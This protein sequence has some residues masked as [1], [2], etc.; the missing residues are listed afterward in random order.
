VQEHSEPLGDATQINQ[1]G[2]IDFMHDKRSNG[3]VIRLL[4]VV[5]DFNRGGLGI[6]M[7]HSLPSE[8]VARVL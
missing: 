2:S 7:D 1:I 5:D 3:R 8:R 4:N 6:K